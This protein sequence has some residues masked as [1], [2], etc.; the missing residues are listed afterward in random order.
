MV[1]FIGLQTI[2]HMLEGLGP[3]LSIANVVRFPPSPILGEGLGVRAGACT[4]PC[5]DPE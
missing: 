3:A 1:L 5:P 2:D 4:E